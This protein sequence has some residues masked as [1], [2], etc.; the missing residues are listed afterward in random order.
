[1]TFIADIFPKLR[2]PKNMVRSIPKKSHFRG[3]YKKQ[4]GKRA[5]TLFKFEGNL[6]PC[7]LITGKAIVLQKVSVSNMQNLETVSSNT[8]CQREVFFSC[9]RQFNVTN[10]DVIISKTKNFVSI[11]ILVLEI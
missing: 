3:S 1:M 8:V 11:F 4:H 6:F 7:L 10:S 2:T 5:K 9:Y